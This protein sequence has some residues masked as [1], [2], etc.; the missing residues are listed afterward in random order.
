[1][2]QLAATIEEQRGR[3]ASHSIARRGLSAHVAQKIE[4][5]HFPASFQIPL[6]PIRDG[7]GQK[8]SA[9]GIGIEL[10]QSWLAVL[11]QGIQLAQVGNIAGRCPQDQKGGDQTQDD[12][13]GDSVF[14]KETKHHIHLGFPFHV[15]SQRDG[16]GRTDRHTSVTSETSASIDEVWVPTVYLNQGLALARGSGLTGPASQASVLSDVGDGGNLRLGSTDRH[17]F[18]PRNFVYPSRVYKVYHG[19][20]QLSS[21][22]ACLSAR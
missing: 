18:N 8:A 13:C 11:Q 5:K 9:S 15:C 3:H 16:F 4:P 12:D 22:E 7:F 17:N 10:H 14:P 19:C 21:F 2:N 6:Q 1:M 20:G